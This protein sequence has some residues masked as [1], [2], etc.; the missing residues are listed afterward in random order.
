[1]VNPDESPLEAAQRELFEETGYMAPDWQALG[2]FVVDGN[3]QCGTA[4]LFLARNA[5]RVA[6]ANNPDINESVE[7]ELMS[8]HQ[9]LRVLADGGVALLATVGAVGLA[10]LSKN[11]LEKN[12]TLTGQSTKL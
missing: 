7:V 11:D 10:M 2:S 4:H 5:R 12:Q 9:F 8:P 6:P 3:R 1:L